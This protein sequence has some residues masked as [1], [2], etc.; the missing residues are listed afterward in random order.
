MS[1]VLEVLGAFI[2]PA[3]QAIQPTTPFEATYPHIG[4][5]ITNYG[6]IEVGPSDPYQSL[7][8]A[9]EPGGLVW[10]SQSHDVAIHVALCRLD[11]HLEAWMNTYYGST[12]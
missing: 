7:V 12:V 4:R 6:W 1:T 10:E 2:E 5:W 3:F 11:R 8:R 9:F